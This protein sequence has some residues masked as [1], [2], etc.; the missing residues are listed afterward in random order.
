MKPNQITSILDVFEPFRMPPSP[1]DKYNVS[2]KQLLMDR[3][4]PFVEANVPIEFAMLGYPMKSPNVR[5][6]VIGN[7][8]DMGEELSFKNFERF[9]TEMRK[10]YSPGVKITIISDGYVFSDVL[11][12]S[13]K[14]VAM[15]EE[16]C[17]DMSSSAPVD[18]YDL[19]DFYS[20]KMPNAYLRDKLM[21]QFGITDEA[22]D[23][24]IQFDPDTNALYRGMI[25][26]LELDLAIRDY[27][28]NSQ[29]HK[30]AKRVARTMMFRNEAYSALI[31]SEFPNYIRLSMHPSENNGTKY[32]FQL[33]PSPKAWTSPWHCAMLLNSEGIYET[34]HK[35]DA[36]AAGHELVYT[37]GQPY[38]FSAK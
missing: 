32:S 19:T 18:W 10:V 35:K 2:G 20:R 22:L 8:P 5:D 23:R 9:D 31:K 3:M 26:F 37:N 13:D 16:Q 38:Y 34:I 15:Y 24:R 7:Q 25:R 14:I 21:L 36:I 33:I 28:S 30:E 17:V 6:K 27:P 29:L 1:I 11:K 12:V 4:M